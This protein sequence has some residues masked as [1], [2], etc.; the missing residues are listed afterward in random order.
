[1][2]AGVAVQGKAPPPKCILHRS[3]FRIKFPKIIEKKNISVRYSSTTTFQDVPTYTFR[4][5]HRGNT[6]LLLARTKKDIQPTNE[7]YWLLP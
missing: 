2:Y 7:A 4:T 3:K 5:I 1:M 6:E